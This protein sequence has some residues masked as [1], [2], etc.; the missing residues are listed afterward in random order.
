MYMY[1]HIRTCM[2][3]YRVSH[4]RGMVSGHAKECCRCYSVSEFSI[5]GGREL[6]S[7]GLS[8]IELQL[9]PNQH[10]YTVL[11]AHALRLTHIC[12]L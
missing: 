5:H 9:T 10:T 3:V 2:Y 1:M 7:A 12:L 11:G 4:A 6:D 8:V